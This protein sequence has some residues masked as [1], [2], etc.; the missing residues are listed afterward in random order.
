MQSFLH[1]VAQRIWNE[2][3]QDLD[4]VLVVFN[5]RR[6]GLFL[7][8][9]MLT[10]DDKPFFLPQIIGI[11]DLVSELGKMRIAP[12]EFLLFELFDIH[13]S[14][15]G[16]DRHYQTFEEFISFGETM[17]SDFSEIDLYCV[18]AKKLFNNISELKKLGEWDVSDSKL[19]PFQKKYLDFYSSLYTY[20]TQFRQRLTE[21]KCAYT[22][23]AYRNVAENIDSMAD[24]LDFSHIYFVGFNALSNCESKIIDCCVKRGIGSLICDGDDYYFS[25][26]RQEA[27]AFLRKNAECFSDIGGF[28]NHFAQGNK[29][30]HIINSPEN[31]L[32]TK[33]A[34]QILKNLLNSDEKIKETAI[35]LAD[36]GLLLPMLNSLPEQIHS[37]NVTMGYPFVLTGI[38]NLATKLLALYCNAK[39]ERFYHVDVIDI[40]SDAIIS[41]YLGTNSL[42]NSITEFVNKNKL[43]YAS[44]GDIKLMLKGISN[45]DNLLF[46]F[47]KCSLNADEILELLRR[48]VELIITSDILEKNTK[49]KESVSCF[50]QI[51]NYL[52]DL[53]Q[54]YHFIE[55]PSTLQRIYQRIAQRRSVAF[56][57]EPLQGLQLL[58][59]LE[60]RSLDFPNIVML[61]VNEGTLPAGRSSNSLIPYSLKKSKDF[62]IPTFEEKDAVYAY[63]FYRLLQRT[64]EAWLIYSSDSDG[65]GKGEPSRF[66]LQIKNELAVR[67]PNISIQEEVLSVPASS[68]QSETESGIHKDEKTMQRLKEMAVG[69][70]EKHIFLSPTAINRYRNCPMQFYY[71]DVLGVHEQEEISEDLEANELG[72]L[73][74]EILKNIYTKDRNVKKETLEKALKET[75]NLVETMLHKDILKGRDDEGKNRLY[76]EVAKT[77]ITRFLQKEIALL[78]PPTP[79]TPSHTIE[80]KLVEKPI[81]YDLDLTEFGITYPI[82]IEGIADRIDLF[83]GILRI[84]DYKSGG[85]DAADLT[86]KEP[87]PNPYKVSDKWFQVYFL[88]WPICSCR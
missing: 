76:S 3:R 4:R 25:D 32:Q 53:Q 62:N 69:N 73:I 45:S 71:N 57:G 59:M 8:K 46:L 28:E 60:T 75:D 87:E 51:L 47:E 20:Y 16:D 72:T 30:L 52:D 12:H 33:A 39:R 65:M 24:T 82:H 17:I 9:E 31:V 49:E 10:L 11:D 14:L 79:N 18:D 5:N 55:K 1:S 13:R 42:H 35:V 81:A 78:D 34:G 56:Y 41:K 83:D 40:L 15:D 26:S 29:I 44:L 19:T 7:Q 63:N 48:I 38:H 58:G 86:V 54:K 74:H 77:Q 84:A 88:Y 50:I 27:G 61:S 64:N 43:I 36:E 2:H 22:G 6:A 85:V 37:T 80:I 70:S 23:M 66:I 67:H 21:A 68:I